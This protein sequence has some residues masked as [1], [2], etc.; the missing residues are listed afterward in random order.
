[1]SDL[2]T[3]LS[4]EKIQQVL[5]GHRGMAGYMVLYRADCVDECLCMTTC[6][7]DRRP[8]APALAAPS[9]YSTNAA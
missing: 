4:E 5:F 2:Q 8:C 1:M 7:W 3:T 9:S 6:K